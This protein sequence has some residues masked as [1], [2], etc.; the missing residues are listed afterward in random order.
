MTSPSCSTARPPSPVFCSSS[1]F[2]VG[3]SVDR[4]DTYSKNGEV[5]LEVRSVPNT[6]KWDMYTVYTVF[7]F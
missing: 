1:L 6:V 5:G 4:S 3:A 2:W 7:H